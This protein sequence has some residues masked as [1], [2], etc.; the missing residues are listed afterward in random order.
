MRASEKQGI[1]VSAEPEKDI[2]TGEKIYRKHG[3]KGARGEAEGGFKSSLKAL[4]LL[5]S[6]LKEGRDFNLSLADVLI[7]IISETEDTNIPGRNSIE[8]LSYAEKMCRNFIMS[9]GVF[10]ENGIEE[11]KKLDRDFIEKKHK[12][13]RKCRYSCNNTFSLFHGQRK[14]F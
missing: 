4:A 5:Y 13:G 1:S 6:R 3:I 9:G 2:T 7:H 14:F 11:L 12:P 8:T 10:R